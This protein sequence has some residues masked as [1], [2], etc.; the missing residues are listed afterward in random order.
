MFY[1]FNK[2]AQAMLLET[3]LDSSLEL[4]ICLAAF[5]DHIPDIISKF[6]IFT[7]SPAWPLPSAL[8]WLTTDPVCGDQYSDASTEDF[9]LTEVYSRPTLKPGRGH[10]DAAGKVLPFKHTDWTWIDEVMFPGSPAV[11]GDRNISIMRDREELARRPNKVLPVPNLQAQ[12][13]AP[14]SSI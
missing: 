9:V 11:P 10:I 3:T 7:S 12:V 13:S 1:R 14:V 8:L 4:R 2:S 6:L 5:L